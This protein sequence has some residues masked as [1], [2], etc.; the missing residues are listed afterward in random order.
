MHGS[1]VDLDFVYLVSL[2]TNVCSFANCHIGIRRSLALTHTSLDSQ[3]VQGDRV[4]NLHFD[5]AACSHSLTAC[6]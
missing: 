4:G 1:V 6:S 2:C 5:S 3:L